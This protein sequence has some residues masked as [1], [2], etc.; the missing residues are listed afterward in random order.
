M[1]LA[2]FFQSL[3]S[4]VTIEPVTSGVG[5]AAGQAFGTFF[6]MIGQ[7]IMTG[8]YWL[9]KWLLAIVD[10]LQYFIQKLIGLDYWINPR[11][12]T[13]Q[14]ATRND[15]LF[16]FLYNDTVQRV[17]RA[18][19][20][21]FI[22]LLIIF[23]IFAIV[24]N[25]WTFIT[26][27]SFG[28]GKGN[29]K[30][31]II[32]DS[33]KAIGLVMIFPLVLSIGIIAANAILASLINALSIDMSSTFGNKLFYVSS[34]NANKYKVY[35]EDMVETPI[36]DTVTFYVDNDG[37][38]L[39]LSTNDSSDDYIRNF[40]EYGDYLNA[41][42]EN[43]VKKYTVNSSFDMV[44][45]GDE[46]SFNG[47]CIG[48]NYS[49]KTVYY[50]VKV[51]NPNEQTGNGVNTPAA[52]YYY[53]RSVLGVN[54]M[55]R[56]NSLGNKELYDDVKGRMRSGASYPGYITGLKLSSFGNGEVTA[57]CRQTWNYFTIFNHQTDFSL[58][59]G[60]INLRA[61]DPTRQLIG[62]GG[63][64]RLSK[65]TRA[66]LMYNAD[67]TSAYFDG[68]QRGITQM[69]A[70]YA[71]MGNVVDYMLENE[72]KLY[73]LDVT[74]PLIK[75]GAPT[76]Y[77]TETEKLLHDN[78]SYFNNLSTWIPENVNYEKGIS[79]ALGNWIDGQNKN[80]FPFVVSY[81][82]EC[83]DMEAGNTLYLA[84]NNVGNELEGSVYIMCIRIDDNNFVPLI[85]RNTFRGS[86]GTT[87]TFTSDYLESNYHGL[88]VAKGTFD[89]TSYSSN[90]VLGTPTYLANRNT[91]NKD[92]SVYVDNAPYYYEM[93]SVGG[94]IQCIADNDDR[95]KPKNVSGTVNSIQVLNGAGGN[96]YYFE[97]ENTNS[98][99][100][101]WRKSNPS[102]TASFS[103]II[104]DVQV[105]MSVSG[106]NTIATYADQYVRSG[107]NIYYLFRCSSG[108]YFAIEETTQ[109]GSTLIYI[110]GID[111][112]SSGRTYN[113]T[114]SA[115]GTCQLVNYFYNVQVYNSDSTSS[116]LATLSV[117]P[118]Q[119]LQ[120]TGID[121]SYSAY[122]TLD[123]LDYT[124]GGESFSSRATVYF[125]G[126]AVSLISDGNGEAKI[127]FGQPIYYSSSSGVSKYNEFF[128]DHGSSTVYKIYLYDFSVGAVGGS[129]R[130]SYDKYK[131]TISNNGNVSHG[132]P[133]GFPTDDN[134]IINFKVNNGFDW[135]GAN[136]MALY[137]GKT[138]VA[139]VYKAQGT[140]I[141]NTDDF[142]KKSWSILY[143][144]NTYYNLLQ[145]N[146]YTNTDQ[147][148]THY[149]NISAN[150]RVACVRDNIDVS[151]WG[152]FKVD[153]NFN[154]FN[155]R[156]IGTFYPAEISREMTSIEFVISD[157]I[158]YDYFFDGVV[159]L[160]TFY[161][162]SG[163]NYLILI[164]GSI[165]IIKVLGT[166]LW[167]VIKRFYEI[168]LY[169]IAMPAV[170]STIPLDGGSRFNAQIQQ[171]L[172]KKVLSTYGVLL[173]I[174]VFFVLLVPVESMSKVFTAEDIATSGNHFLQHLPFSVAILNE[175]VYILFLLVAFTMIQALPKVISDMVGA[176]NALESGEK[177]KGDAKKS[178]ASVG[179]TV[180]GQNVVEGMKGIGKAVKNSGVG[181]IVGLG[182]RAAKAGA[183]FIRD[184]TRQDVE[185]DEENNGNGGGNG[186]GSSRAGEGGD[187]DESAEATGGGGA[188]NA[189]AENVST[190]PARQDEFTRTSEEQ[191]YE[192]QKSRE[193]I[194]KDNDAIMEG[195][196]KADDI[197]GQSERMDKAVD[198]YFG[199]K[200][201]DDM[202]KKITRME[203]QG[204]NMQ[205][206]KAQYGTENSDEDI[207]RAYLKTQIVEGSK[208]SD[209]LGDTPN[210]EMEAKVVQGMRAGK[211]HG[212]N[213]G[214]D[215]AKSTI[216]GMMTD[217]EKESA[218]EAM[219]YNNEGKSF[220][221]QKFGN[222][223]AKSFYTALQKQTADRKVEKTREDALY[224]Q[225]ER[226]VTNDMIANKLAN[227]D[228]KSVLYQAALDMVKGRLGSN[229]T[230]SDMD[231][232][233][234]AAANG[235]L[236]GVIG[237]L[238]QTPEGVEAI[239]EIKHDVVKEF[240][241][242]TNGG[243]EVAKNFADMDS[244]QRKQYQ[245]DLATLRDRF[246]NYKGESTFTDIINNNKGAALIKQKMKDEGVDTG[247]SKAV[248]KYL[249]ANQDVL[250]QV[251]SL[252]ASAGNISGLDGKKKFWNKNN[253]V[254]TGRMVGGKIARV[255]G[256]QQTVSWLGKHTWNKYKTEGKAKDLGTN[257]ATIMQAKDVVKDLKGVDKSQ[258]KA[259]LDELF[260]NNSYAK[261]LIEKAYKGVKGAKYR[262]PLNVFGDLENKSVEIQRR[263]IMKVLE[264]NLNKNNKRLGKTGD[265][266]SAG[267]DIV[268]AYAGKRF[269]RRMSAA[270]SKYGARYQNIGGVKI[271]RSELVNPGM[272]AK[273]LAGMTAKE[274]AQY[275]NLM[276]NSASANAKYNAQKAIVEQLQAQL[277]SSTGL[278]K[279]T[280]QKLL[281]N[282]QI[283]LNA[284]GAVKSNADG[285]KLN[286]EK[287]Y[288][289][290]QIKKAKESGSSGYNTAS[291]LLGKYMFPY[292]KGG[293]VRPGS[294]DAKQVE[295]AVRK[296]M[297][298]MGG[299]EEM[300]NLIKKNR[301]DF[302]KMIR[303]VKEKQDELNRKRKK[304]E[305]K[306][307]KESKE[308]KTKLEKTNRQLKLI[309]DELKKQLASLGIDISN[310][311]TR[312]Y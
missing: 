94:V 202:K 274:L 44:V 122:E 142:V 225:N 78:S 286:F 311:K 19:V 69:Q 246:E 190:A 272:S 17:F 42:K 104:G 22:I 151:L 195:F 66:K 132:N 20:V 164:V 4:A 97:S 197:E 167:G 178:M 13:L 216:L 228:P 271:D 106:L 114:E 221:E 89:T 100:Y 62:P 233:H 253:W 150:Y 171:P 219:I 137:D 121:E 76:N 63:E 47:Y 210:P 250:N 301:G 188:A 36:S 153:T 200:T 280:T 161:I 33:L 166:A 41:I 220:L 102:D 46:K 5:G 215:L 294:A 182:R 56:S 87:Y 305:Y 16:T 30:S 81:S 193:L 291:N 159:G 199:L 49:D 185:D 8:F 80:A 147:L 163:I 217:E 115:R 141:N 268:Q 96:G 55:T 128:K 158:E 172:I 231:I 146:Y 287:A 270:D 204:L 74:S 95:S 310:I 299:I 10:F 61:S 252:G 275:K 266:I 247:D 84:K 180:S 12:V 29:S 261:E 23:T 2:M 304:L 54:I 207:V 3:I 127:S 309:T 28:D 60:Y 116:P 50:M 189:S 126:N 125:E 37:K 98:N 68:G 48:I 26:G 52:W 107:S 235:M 101:Y 7:G 31:K 21:V 133:I 53:L 229:A 276:S 206:L 85:A 227:S 241:K 295:Q 14:G 130:G 308:L 67:S 289:E 174:N 86:D 113:F 18:I 135:N 1:K 134:F 264:S 242:N 11:N 71:V 260:K 203:Y 108:Y 179:K 290:A 234:N 232:M 35:A 170:A 27:G 175:Y 176:D 281:A 45:P 165:L 288:A 140:D 6:Q 93:K 213:G 307:D 43:N 162:A 222:A 154:I 244:D 237:E 124:I 293:H 111:T 254:N 224:E 278:K 267:S 160:S 24:K 72:I 302:A 257:I 91:F 201:P 251:M 109:N 263:A 131:V 123:F 218:T 256:V 92:N 187:A 245:D 186:G 273:Q 145:S 194:A 79:E 298:S 177:T 88:V 77:N 75:W 152:M 57:A 157:G 192:E 223:G 51:S 148:D 277:T 230:G 181:Q 226:F 214:Y 144:G 70:E 15:L 129:D 265:Y 40:N 169:F 255:T 105:T 211:G 110:K 25:E 173:G 64:M 296:F 284:I 292:K 236:A 196:A 119:D 32:R 117:D 285:K 112:G 155:W 9:C 269:S 83:L 208:I 118:Y 156:W 149:E 138:Y 283:K 39:K 99:S 184:H 103:D 279:A 73:V 212:I 139:Q 312:P 205:S 248:K 239:S 243:M 38:Y 191:E 34:L 306:T 82:D 183:G 262:G 240:D 249:K 303:S 58:A 209:F 90:R 120:Y 65:L 297:A 198:A 282:A 59:N 136:D 143:N 258:F 300:K 238:N 259:K 168:T